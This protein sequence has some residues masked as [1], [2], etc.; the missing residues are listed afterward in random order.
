[1]L[2]ITKKLASQRPNIIMFAAW[3]AYEAFLVWVLSRA[4][5]AWREVLIWS[6]I[7]L[8]LACLGYLW[9]GQRRRRKFEERFW[10]GQCSRCGYDLRGQSERCP[11][12]GEPL[13]PTLNAR[14]N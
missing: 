1:M 11:E 12:C 9:I 6:A 4:R 8:P 14:V 10:R 2:G 5:S 13:R 3:L 7:L